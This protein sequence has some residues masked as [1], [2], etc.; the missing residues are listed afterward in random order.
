MCHP[1]DANCYL[2]IVAHRG[3]SP[4]AGKDL[5]VENC[6]VRTKEG[7]VSSRAVANVKRLAG[8]ARVSVI[9]CG[10]DTKNISDIYYFHNALS[11]L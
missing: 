7:E 4:I 2:K 9:P 10:I 5:L 3:Y 11:F 1:V 8:R 6:P